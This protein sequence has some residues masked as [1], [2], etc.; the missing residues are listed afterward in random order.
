MY[1]VTK[2][3]RKIV[4]DTPIQIAIAVYSYAK[5][6]LIEFW[7]FINKYLVNDLYQLMEC[8]TDS[9][10]IAF[11]RDTIDECVKAELKDEWKRVK[12]DFFSSEDDTPFDFNGH[13]IPFKQYD[14]RTPGKFKPE[15]IG[16]GMICLN[17]K[18]FHCWGPET[19]TSC[20]G[21]QKKRNVLVR[22]N[23]LKLL[24]TRDPEMITN[25]GFIQ[26]DGKILTYT[27]TKKGLE[28]FYGK[29]KIMSDGVSSTH[30]D[31]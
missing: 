6:R 27:Q 8:D 1:E 23:F 29:R 3:K 10:Y 30:L 9:L 4:H 17:S 13:E 28:Y 12:W 24:R 19:K 11:A 20:K 7:E 16:M 15:F 18:V 22:E 31:I 14:K 2:T 5:L 21:T 25:A 26:E